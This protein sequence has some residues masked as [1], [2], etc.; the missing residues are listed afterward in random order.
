MTMF[1]S[2]STHLY[3]SSPH[4]FNLCESDSSQH[5]GDL[6]SIDAI[7]SYRQIGDCP[8]SLQP[9]KRSRQ[10]F[11]A[12]FSDPETAELAGELFIEAI[13]AQEAM[14]VAQDHA[15]HWGIAVFSLTTASEKQIRLH[16]LRIAS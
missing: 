11:L 13:S 14:T 6:T 16:R 15:H 4:D 1:G 9:Q 2:S 7:A 10:L 12:E 8:A 3:S 5:S